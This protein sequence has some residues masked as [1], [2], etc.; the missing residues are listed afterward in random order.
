MHDPRLRI[1]C[2]DAR[3]ASGDGQRYDII[4][5]D[6]TYPRRADEMSLWKTSFF[7]RLRLALSP[8]GVA[9]INAVS[10]E[11]TPR[12]FGCIGATLEAARLFAFPYTFELPSFRAEGYGR[13]GFFLP[14]AA[15]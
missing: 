13:W 15:R 6:L 8:E 12:A 3:L 5:I 2:E 14:R 4:I 10:P 7:R 9:A 1:D 11:H